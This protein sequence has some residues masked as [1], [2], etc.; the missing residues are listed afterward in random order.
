MIHEECERTF[1]EGSPRRIIGERQK[2][3]RRLE[4]D[5]DKARRR[6]EDIA[7]KASRKIDTIVIDGN[8]LCYEGNTF[9]GLSAIEALLPSLV[10]VCSVVVVFDSAI[11]RMLNT[12]DS[13]IQK[14]LGRRARV[15]IV[16]SRRL[17]DETVLDLASGSEGVYVLSND[18]FGDFNEKHVVR[19]GRI[20]RHEIVNGNIFVHDLQLRA[21]Y[22]PERQGVA[23]MS[24]AGY[25]DLMVVAHSDG[26][27]E[28][29]A[30]GQLLAGTAVA[31]PRMI[32]VAGLALIAPPRG[33]QTAQQYKEWPER[34]ESQGYQVTDV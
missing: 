28:V 22:S 14:R 29:F 17:A 20:I 2:E 16:A 23:P 25:V 12:T 7:R 13:G 10:R 32:R 5:F 34:L 30:P 31:N 1:G 26:T 6:V 11:R 9:I 21:T 8:N 18:R 3:V 27:L 19:D 33:R 4:R 24:T 15:H